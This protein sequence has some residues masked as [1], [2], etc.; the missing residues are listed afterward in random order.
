MD[1]RIGVYTTQDI[2]DKFTNLCEAEG[3]KVSPTL[4]RYMIRCIKKDSII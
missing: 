3:Y 4:K 2:R 1:A